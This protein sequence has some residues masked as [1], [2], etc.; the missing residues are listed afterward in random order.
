MSR[1]RDSKVLNRDNQWRVDCLG[2]EENS[3]MGR[4]FHT[5]IIIHQPIMYD[6]CL[7]NV[8]FALEKRSPNN[9]DPASSSIPTP[10]FYINLKFGCRGRG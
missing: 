2:K 6:R 9:Y 8:L 1:K 10:K 4:I 5:E 7:L 3:F